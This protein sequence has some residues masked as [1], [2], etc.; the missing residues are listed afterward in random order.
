MIATLL[1]GLLVVFVLVGIRPVGWVLRSVWREGGGPLLV[2]GRSLHVLA[3]SP[4]LVASRLRW[5]CWRLGYLAVVPPARRNPES[6]HGA[7]GDSPGDL[8][9]PD[10]PESPSARS[11]AG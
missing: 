10:A 7:F 4:V 3:C 6:L 8:P 2:L 5:H 11:E 9:P 1:L